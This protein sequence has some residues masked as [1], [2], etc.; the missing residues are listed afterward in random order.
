MTMAKLYFLIFILSIPLHG[1]S[2]EEKYQDLAKYCILSNAL[3]QNVGEFG[4]KSLLTIQS[5]ID[6]L[7]D[8]IKSEEYSFGIELLGIIGKYDIVQITD[9]TNFQLHGLNNSIWVIDRNV[10]EVENCIPL[11]KIHFVDFVNTYLY[12]NISDYRKLSIIEAYKNT[13]LKGNNIF[14]YDSIDDLDKFNL[15]RD[16]YRLD[17]P[18]Q[19]NAI[20]KDK[21][22]LGKDSYRYETFYKNKTDGKTYYYSIMFLFEWNKFSVLETSLYEVKK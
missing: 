14:F 10:D 19:Y 2:L 20:V 21:S 5:D 12:A 17:G 11:D 18:N 22:S 16:E 7:S 15:I 6:N 8:I 3:D 4:Q 1:Q 9:S 13:V